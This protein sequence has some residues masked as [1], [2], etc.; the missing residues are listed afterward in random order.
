MNN[1]LSPA[2]ARLRLPLMGLLP[3]REVNAG[4]L[5][6]LPIPELSIAAL[7]SPRLLHTAVELDEV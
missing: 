5:P 7:N 3:E 4:L 6:K 1:S 2:A